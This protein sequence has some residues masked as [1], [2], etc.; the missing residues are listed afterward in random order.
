VDSPDASPPL[1]GRRHGLLS[2]EATRS[3]TRPLLYIRKE[4]EKGVK[5]EIETFL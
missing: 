2:P 3:L 5:N 4:E 1:P